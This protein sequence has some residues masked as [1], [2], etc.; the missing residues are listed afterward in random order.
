[1]DPV[2]F[3]ASPT[4][5]MLPPTPPKILLNYPL[6]M[7]LLKGAAKRATNKCQLLARLYAPI[8]E[9]HDIEDL[10]AIACR[11]VNPGGRHPVSKPSA[12]SRNW[13]RQNWSTNSES[14][15][16]AN[17]AESRDRGSLQAATKFDI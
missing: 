12:K 15:K 10:S 5:H 2:A 8:Q 16:I 17:S 11:W 3:C 4:R 6:C 7:H 13:L 14:G 9:K 1:M